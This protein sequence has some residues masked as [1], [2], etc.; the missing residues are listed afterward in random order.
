MVKPQAETPAEG[1]DA[2]QIL[3][4]PAAKGLK[5]PAAAHPGGAQNVHRMSVT[6]LCGVVFLLCVCFYA[7]VFAQET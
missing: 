2:D 6:C 3:K 4:K 7:W 5:R 1:S